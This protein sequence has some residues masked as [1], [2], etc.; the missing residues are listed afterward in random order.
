MKKIVYLMFLF[1][2]VLVGCEE[3]PEAG[4]LAPDVKTGEVVEKYRT[5]AILAGSFSDV[6]SSA[7]TVQECG[8]LLSVVPSMADAKIYR[9]DVK[10]S[11]QT[12]EV[13]VDGLEAGE[14]YYYQAYAYSGTSRMVGEALSFETPLKT[15]PVLSELTWIKESKRDYRL[16][17]SIIDEGGSAIRLR[18]FCWKLK[19]E[20]GEP[21]FEKDENEFLEEHENFNEFRLSGL[22]ADS[23]YVLRAFAMNETGTGYSNLISFVTDKLGEPV[24]DSEI[25]P[26]GSPEDIEAV[27]TPE[28]L[29]SLEK[30]MP[31][32]Y[33]NTPPI[34][35]GA[36]LVEPN[37]AVYCQDY[38]V[39]GYAPGTICTSEQIRFF[40]QDNEKLVL[41]FEGKNVT[42]SSHEE[43]SGSFISGSGN[44]FTVYFDTEGESN[45]IYVRLAEV[46]SGTVTAEGIKDLYHAFVMVEKGEDP[47][48]VL[49][50]EGVFR[51]FKD[52]DGLAALHPW[53]SDSRSVGSIFNSATMRISDV[54]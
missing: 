53:D 54:K 41:D 7:G 19:S 42:G 45:G 51:L 35:E 15:V 14:T 13:T 48:Q 40:N 3:Y 37:E 10:V 39:G 22:K 44:N 2:C 12:F 28:I 38:G 29:D 34:V 49:M 17:T 30:Y 11:G 33:G 21:T 20:G 23:E 31:I 4:P 52:G 25:L 1:L 6:A 36:Y 16:S 50:G 5:R 8:V 32:Y 18:G 46:Y 26:W 43:G 27:V 24:F 9:S 47:N